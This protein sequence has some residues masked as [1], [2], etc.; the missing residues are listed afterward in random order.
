MPLRKIERNAQWRRGEHVREHVVLL[1]GSCSK[2]LTTVRP[3]F[4]MKLDVLL[5]FV[6]AV[7]AAKRIVCSIVSLNWLQ[8]ICIQLFSQIK[9]LTMNECISI[10]YTFLPLPD[11]PLDWQSSCVESW[12]MHSCWQGY[13]HSTCVR[14][15]LGWIGKV[16]ELLFFL[17]WFW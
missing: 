11:R 7:Y 15:W 3:R 9:R 10:R 1:S 16:V 2:Q 6:F 5:V 8:K 17:V 14:D 12:N 4:K 13:P